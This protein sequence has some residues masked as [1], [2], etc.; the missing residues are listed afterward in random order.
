MDRTTKPALLRWMKMVY[1]DRK[2]R[3]CPE[4]SPIL[5]DSTPIFTAKHIGVLAAFM[6][7]EVSVG[8]QGHLFTAAFMNGSP[9]IYPNP[10]NLA[11]GGI[12]RS[13]PW[14][15]HPD[16]EELNAFAKAVLP[17]FGWSQEAPAADSILHIYG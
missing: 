12:L 10:I 11:T 4:M 16:N 6:E 8:R 14:M 7:L 3:L 15:A 9:W 17:Y 5:R 1:L 13:H 2:G